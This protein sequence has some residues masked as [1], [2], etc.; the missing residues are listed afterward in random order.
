MAEAARSRGYAY[1][2]ITDHS[3]TAHYAGGLSVD[4]IEEQH[5]E[6]DRLNAAFDGQFPHLQGHR[7]ATSCRTARSITPTTSCAAS[8]SSSA[9]STASSAWSR[10]RRPSASCAPSP[11][12]SSTILGHMTGRQLLRR[13]GYEL[14]IERVL[15]ACAR[16]GVAVEINGNPWRLDLDWRWHRRGAELGCHV[17]HQPRRPFDPARSILDALGRRDGAQGRARQ[18]TGSSTRSTAGDFARWLGRAKSPAVATSIG[19]QAEDRPE[20]LQGQL[21]QQDA[22][23]QA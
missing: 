5:A 3:Q 9:A 22:D 21:E 23:G 4:E 8:T 10:R 11:I 7:I 6:I 16:H 18:P 17:Q 1:I 15:A 19:R 14:D 13:P 20:A 2:G 12:R